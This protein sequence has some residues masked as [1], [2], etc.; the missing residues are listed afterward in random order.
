[1]ILQHSTFSGASSP[2][3]ICLP[4]SQWQKQTNLILHHQL[5]LPRLRVARSSSFK[6]TC[7]V[8][9]LFDAFAQIA[10]NKVLIAAFTSALVGQLVKPLTS[11]FLYGKKFDV[12]SVIDT[13]G[14]PS[15]HSSATVASATLLGLERGFSDPFFG[16]TFVYTGL[17]MYD[18]QGVRKEVG[19]H[20][21]LLNKLLIQTQLNSAIRS[22]NT[23]ANLITSKPL[24]SKG[25]EASSMDPTLRNAY[26]SIKLN[27]PITQ[28]DGEPSSSYGLSA[29]DAAELCRLAGEDG[30]IPFKE[31][32]GHTSNEV[33]GGA[34]LGFLVGLLLHNFLR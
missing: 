9:G 29:A 34:V 33:F 32:V 26:L 16:I 6:I 23:D 30:L 17:I 19:T 1:M 7:F 11:V 25:Q 2:S 21:K 18:A 8:P 22:K 14:F 10:S 31:S 28:I 13:G 3:Q 15:T 24:V 4:L 20:A 5:P 12:R 27:K